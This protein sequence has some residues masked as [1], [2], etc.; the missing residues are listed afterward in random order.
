MNIRLATPDDI[1]AIARV[2]LDSWRNTYRGIMPDDYLDNLT[3]EEREQVWAGVLGNPENR[4]FA[5]VA[6]DEENRIV[7]FGA[8]GL[9]ESN[10][11]A[12]EGE[13]FAL[14]VVRDYHGRG[15]GHHLISAV[16]DRLVQM[17]IHS[18]ILWVI[19]GNPAYGFYER[20]GAARLYEREF[21]FGGVMLTEMGYGWT[22]TSQL[23]Q[24]ILPQ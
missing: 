17:G 20:L 11:P 15:V 6:E 10:D 14:H 21:E 18:M 19:N 1:P 12:Y 3:Y 7:G 23:P 13:L 4:S 2:H 9:S 24:P 8:A 5:L 16:A 22:D